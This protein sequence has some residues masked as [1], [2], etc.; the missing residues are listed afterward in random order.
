LSL[1]KLCGS[2]DGTLR[3]NVTIW[4]KWTPKDAFALHRT[5][6]SILSRGI[7]LLKVGGYIVYSTCSL[8]PIENEAVV[9][10]ALSKHPHMTLVD[11]SDTLPGLKHVAG[12]TSWK[13]MTAD[14]KFHDNYEDMGEHLKKS[15][16]SSC[17]SREDFGQFNLERCLRIH[18]GLQNTG[19]FFVA[20]FKKNYEP[21]KTEIKVNN[22]VKETKELIET[23]A[24]QEVENEE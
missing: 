2:G 15:I 3:K 23:P 7:D 21:E 19:G 5:Q 12:F 10:E 20:L 16:A 22:E 4:D 18:P 24:N 17:F 1:Y 11:T 14:G 9:A 8:N 6:V 13:V